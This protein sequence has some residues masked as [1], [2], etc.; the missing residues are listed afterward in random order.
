MEETNNS[1]NKTI[2]SIFFFHFSSVLPHEKELGNVTVYD[3]G[4]TKGGPHQNER[5]YN[6]ANLT[7]ID[8]YHSVSAVYVLL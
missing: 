6:R 5:A 1:Q 2:V 7:E 3:N 8:N 4:R